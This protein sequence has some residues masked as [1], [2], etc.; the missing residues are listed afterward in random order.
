MATI[1]IS[2]LS[3]PYANSV[4]SAPPCHSLSGYQ[5]AHHHHHSTASP[6]L[7]RPESPAFLERGGARPCPS[8]SGLS[9]HRDT[10]VPMSHTRSSSDSSDGAPPASAPPAAATVTPTEAIQSPASKKRKAPV[11][12]QSPEAEDSRR[13]RPVSWHPSGPVEPRFAPM[14]LPPIA[15]PSILNPAK[16]AAAGG[17]GRDTLGMQ[18][19]LGSSRPPLPSSPAPRLVHP[20]MAHPAKR[21]SLSP[22]LKQR[23]LITPV[24]PSAR[25]V[26]AAGSYSG[27]KGTAH[28]S[29]LAHESRPG[30]YSTPG[31]PLPMDPVLVPSTGAPAGGPPPTSTSVQSTPTF[32]SRRTSAGPTPNLSP[33][34]T[35]PSTP[36][37][38]YSQFGRSSPA[39]TGMS[40]PPSV[41]SILHSSP[42]GV[43]DSGRLP[44]VAAS[45]RYPAEASQ[46]GTSGAHADP[47]SSSSQPGMIP[48][49]LDLKSGSST[50]AEKRKANS[51]ASRRF[52]NRKRNE[53]QMEQKITAQQEEM[54]KQA[55]I[56]QQHAQEIRTLTQER[57]YYR[58]ER[59]SYREQLG[60]FIPPS[61][62]PARS[63]SPRPLSSAVEK[64]TD[65]GNES[66]WKHST[67]PSTTLPD[68]AGL[69]SAAT[70]APVPATRPPVT[71]TTAPSAYSTA[72]SASITS[73]G[74]TSRSLPQPS[75]TRT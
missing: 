31:S 59:D 15:V 58:R 70:M 41:P 47:S 11:D 71:W 39:L 37:S 29:P 34:E 73:D 54:R 55:D 26:G 33:Q 40:G 48:C 65:N 1:G 61:Q 18:Q 38:I 43:A 66:V 24:S 9:S 6:S 12:S 7:S 42:Y 57:D 50:Q 28:H 60:R 53:L 69:P 10:K 63:V 17:S 30:V 51:D 21:L 44:P 8:V 36:Q 3:A 64:S 13:R 5:I 56:L 62:L 20:S 32:H 74:Q 14:Q 22:G 72:Q 4:H 49:T 52:R 67:A 19:M 46:S 27:K 35:S 45:Q 2:V 25:F 23:P 68:P 16:E 75:W